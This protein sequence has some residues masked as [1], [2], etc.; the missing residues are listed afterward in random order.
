M[1]QINTGHFCRKSRQL[2]HSDDGDLQD[3]RPDGRHRSA[4]WSIRARQIARLQSLG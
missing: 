3:L 1:R 4:F 2:V